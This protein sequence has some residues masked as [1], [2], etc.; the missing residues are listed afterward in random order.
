MTVE[1]FC[2]DFKA[3]KAIADAAVY[4]TITLSNATYNGFSIGVTKWAYEKMGLLLGFPV[5]PC[6]EYFRK[7]ERGMQQDTF[8]HS[9]RGVARYT[10]VLSLQDNNGALAFWNH[11]NGEDKPI[12]GTDYRAEGLD[13]SRWK[14][15]HKIDL[16]ENM[17]IIYPAD[18]F[19]SR[20]PKDWDED[21]ARHIQ[22][23]FFNPSKGAA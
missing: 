5:T 18:I 21:Y 9:D 7:Y 4:S 2:P 16:K 8:V 1:N 3:H 23:F 19:H 6:I 10:A 11:V 13:E 22:V 20:Y 15:T 14:M 12:L 17:C